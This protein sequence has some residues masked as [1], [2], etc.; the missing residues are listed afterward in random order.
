MDDINQFGTDNII[1]DQNNEPQLDEPEEENISN[2]NLNNQELAYS[3]DSDINKSKYLPTGNYVGEENNN[4]SIE[5]NN[6]IFLNQ[7]INELNNNILNAN[8]ALQQLENEN[9]NLKQ[10]ILKDQDKI[11]EKDEIGNKYQ[12]LFFSFKQKFLQCEKKNNYLQN[13]IK[14]LEEKLK[15]KDIELK[16]SEKYKIKSETALKSD[17]M[18]KQY[19]DEL[20]NEFK[21]KSK[22]LNQKYCDKEKDL[23]TEY[24]REINNN[25]QKIKDLKIENEKLKYDISEH[26]INIE[27]L[28]NKFGEKDYDLNLILNRKDKEI[29]S[30]KEQL[31]E[32]GKDIDIHHEKLNQDIY[33]YEEKVNKLR[34]ENLKLQNEINIL[35]SEQNENN[36]KINN[37]KHNVL[38]LNNEINQNKNS[39]NNK[40]LIIE[41]LNYQ[42]D[43]MKKSIQQKEI[44]LQ[45]Y[46]QDRQ[47]EI[48]E[49]NNQIEALI[50][51]K[52]LLEAQNEELTENLSLA[53]NGLK[54]FNELIEQKYSSL[55]EELNNQ[56]NTNNLV[57]QKYKNYLKKIKIKQNNLYKENNS[58]KSQI[59][60]QDF[61][62]NKL[63]RTFQYDIKGNNFFNTPKNTEKIIR[64]EFQNNICNMSN[65]IMNYDDENLENNPRKVLEELKLLLKNVDQKLN[66]SLIEKK[67]EYI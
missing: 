54:Q 2:G 57:Q 19:I 42:I 34:E 25:M 10:E 59:N 6:K 21:E 12:N 31:N 63:N 35:R 5:D 16:E 41:Q 66:A 37:Y 47:N 49:L 4:Y 58:L 65:D 46:D 20:Q 9:E 61:M 43:E 32:K 27:N 64:N 48:I 38:M 18:Y 8:P 28:N 29:L 36:N 24:I 3:T 53:N 55:E 50:N 44:D 62:N 14:E 22:K 40:E 56:L 26:K 51:E 33:K 13:Y 67:N 23:K 52:N 15:N 60:G 1:T 11:E 45:N 17:T 39:I 30:L 7:Q